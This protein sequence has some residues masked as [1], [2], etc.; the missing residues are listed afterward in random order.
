M[1]GSMQRITAE[2]AGSPQELAF[3]IRQKMPTMADL[4]NEQLEQIARLVIAQRLTSELNT[5]VDLAGLDWNRERETF[6]N[7]K[8]SNHTRRAYAASLDK[9]E[10][11]TRRA[12]I[13]PLSMNA[14]QADQ[15]IRDLRAGELSEGRE[16]S[17]AS[18]RRDTAAISDTCILSSSMKKPKIYTGFPCF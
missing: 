17:A 1:N 14:A 13:N 3:R 16:V 6:L 11:W 8:G 7:D 2:P 4:D 15:F 5:A 10:A 12:K 18:T 9:L